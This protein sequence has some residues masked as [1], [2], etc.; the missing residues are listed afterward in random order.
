MS[1]DRTAL[2]AKWQRAVDHVETA[3][4]GRVVG[5]ERQARWRPAWFFELERPEGERVSVYFRGA[6]PEA[7]RG[8]DDLAREQ[9]CLE[10]MA[11]SH[12]PV[13]HVYDFCADPPG[14]VMDRLPGRHN[15]ATA[16]DEDER[17]SV[18]TEL[19]GVMARMHDL[20]LEPFEAA[21]F[22]RPRSAEALVMGDFATWTS[23]FEA[24]KSRPEPEIAFGVDW[25]AR[26]MIEGREQVSFL[27]GDAGQFMFDEGHLTGLIDLELAYLG[28]PAAD[29]GALLC[30]D[31]S[32]PLG[33]LSE[34]IRI[35]ERVSGRPVD[36]RA[37]HFHAIRFGLVT[38]L[39]TA[40]LIA[41]PASFLDYVQY[42]SWYLVYLRCPL[43][44]VAHLEGVE[45]DP[46]EL[47]EPVE[48]PWSA[49]HGALVDRIA[50]FDRSD[51]FAA[52]EFEASERLAVYLQRADRFGPALEDANTD[53]AAELLGVRPADPTSRDAA[54]EALVVANEG[55]L[56]AR[57]LTYFVRR[58]LRH[59]FLIEP[60][61]A[62]LAG[63]R[64]QVIS[65]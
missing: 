20:G 41:Q 65:P 49:A 14:I 7:A 48:T 6:R 57:L 45:I 23:N 10:L 17:R 22:T 35:Y 63:A 39:A 27:A 18:I 11:E 16:T 59:E 1:F 60:V 50:G 24:A 64:M 31:L 43:Q 52:Y 51:P 19:M 46:P 33:D 3:V 55:D 53:E 37:V 54:L 12:I 32:E 4:G 56:D 58:L 15:L 29:L 62:E 9:L 34:A 25:L 36:R 42:L 21:G 47:P 5:A 2:S 8:G 44:I 61:A 13:P 30:R 38:P 28:D 40:G 26:N